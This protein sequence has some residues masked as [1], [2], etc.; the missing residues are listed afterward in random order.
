MFISSVYICLRGKFFSLFF[1]CYILIF[2]YLLF[3]SEDF[4]YEDKIDFLKYF[5]LVFK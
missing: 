1:C 5:C 3:F 4:V 2:M